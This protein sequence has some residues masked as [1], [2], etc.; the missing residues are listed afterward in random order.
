MVV[1]VGVLW[2]SVL[3]AEKRTIEANVMFNINVKVPVAILAITNV[4][5]PTVG[6][7][8]R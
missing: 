3:S 1:V 7:V 5:T 2:V 4:E 6:A 8:V